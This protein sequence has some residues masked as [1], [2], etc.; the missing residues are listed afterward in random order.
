MMHQ[1]HILT[2]S[3]EYTCSSWVKICQIK[4]CV[5]KLYVF[6]CQPPPWSYGNALCIRLMGR[7]F[8][9]GLHGSI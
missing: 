9:S 8:D 7:E 5:V 1:N 3:F 4:L 6:L 2:I